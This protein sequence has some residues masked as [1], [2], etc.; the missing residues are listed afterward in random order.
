MVRKLVLPLVAIIG[1]AVAIAMILRGNESAPAAQPVVQPAG[2]PF[3]SYVF[4]PGI[5]E[6][7][8][9]NITIGTPVSGIV[10]AVYVKWGDRVKSGAP[11]FKVD[12]PDL[13]AQL[14]PPPAKVKQ[15]EPH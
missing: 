13:Q 4:G 11:L 12:T 1:F 15:F 2:A 5:V 14:L 6:A 7:S 3:S 9:E 8:S 10:T